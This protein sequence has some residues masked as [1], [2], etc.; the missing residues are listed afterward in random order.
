MIFLM[1]YDRRAGRLVTFTSF[2]EQDRALAE[3]ARLDIELRTERNVLNNEVVL[4][5]AASEAVLRR[6]HRRYFQN[7]RQIIEADRN[8]AS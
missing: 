7:P 2:R 6:T 3:K 4:L 8:A 5:E 1:Q